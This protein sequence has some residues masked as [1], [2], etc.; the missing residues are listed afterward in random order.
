MSDSNIEILVEGHIA[1]L[2]LNRPDVRNAMSP[3]MGRDITAAVRDLNQRDDLRAV[4]IHGRGKSFSAGGD[5]DLLEART[6]DAPDANRRAMRAFYAA[7]LAVRDLRVP[8][9]AA[10]HGH[11]IGAGLCFA[12]ACDIR[13]AA[14]GTKLGLTFARVGLHPG[15]GATFLMPRAVGHAHAAELMLTGRVFDA[16]HAEKIGLVSRVVTR[17]E[18]VSTARDIAAEIANN[19]PV[20]VAQLTDTLRSGGLRTLDQ[21]LDR[22]AACQAIDYTTGDMK[23]AIEAFRNKRKPVFQGS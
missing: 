5:F 14:E 17:I 6:N 20:A 11:A 7:F 10:I 4:I 2:V 19:A 3:E 8:T 12:L 13:I 21:A 16:A 15:M 9:I 18:L 23:E 22:E 1:E